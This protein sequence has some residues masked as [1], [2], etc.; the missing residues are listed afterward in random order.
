MIAEKDILT[1]YSLEKV[2]DFN[3]SPELKIVSINGKT[4]GALCTILM[5]LDMI[6]RKED[7][8]VANNDIIHRHNIQNSVNYFKEKSAEAGVMTFQSSHPKWS[9]VLLD[10]ERV[11][12][13]AEKEVISKNAI[14]GIYWFKEGEIMIEMAKDCMLNMFHKDENYYLS[15]LLNSYVIAN[16]KVLISNINETEISHLYSIDKVK[17]YI[18]ENKKLEKNK[19]NLVIPAAGKGSRFSNAN[20]KD[21][22][23]LIDIN[24]QAMISLVIEDNKIDVE[25]DTFIAI[26]EEHRENFKKILNKLN[27]IHL[28]ELRGITKG[29]ACTVQRVL[30]HFSEDQQF[31]VANSDQICSKSTSKMISYAQENN[32]DGCIMCFKEPSRDEKWSYVKVNKNNYVERVAEKSAISDIAT[33]GIYYFK[34]TLDYLS[35]Y[36]NMLEQ[37]DK[38][39]NE[40][41]SCPVYNY[42]IRSNKKIGIFLIDKNEMIGLGTPED[43]IQYINKMGFP[44]SKSYPDLN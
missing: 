12:M 19:V 23:P 25:T 38:V 13:A 26:Q 14:A 8:L 35:A 17:D 43:L 5:G 22:K 30:E 42:L 1:K 2:C 29:T 6:N 7:I 11:L 24:G 31:V 20:W 9:Y 16:K 36:S 28:I 37:D 34:S 41:Y 44:P 3:G 15:G 32:L 4:S 18:S 21:P 39:N 27:N 33:V 40:F 10:N